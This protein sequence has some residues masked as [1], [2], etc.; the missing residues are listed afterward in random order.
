LGKGYGIKIGTIGNNLWHLWELDE[1]NGSIM[2]NLVRT[3][4]GRKKKKTMVRIENTNILPH[5]KKKKQRKN[6]EISNPNSVISLPTSFSF[7]DLLLVDFLT[8]G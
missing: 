2:G 6:K 4:L 7:Y 8:L 3:Q 1:H 5:P